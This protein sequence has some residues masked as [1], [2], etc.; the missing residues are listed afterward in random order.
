MDGDEDSLFKNPRGQISLSDSKKKIITNFIKWLGK[1]VISGVIVALVV[2]FLVFGTGWSPFTS[3]NIQVTDQISTEDE[4]QIV[5]ANS[6]NFRAEDVSI[7]VSSSEV[8][9]DKSREVDTLI[10]G[11]TR[12]LSFDLNTANQTRTVNRTGVTISNISR[13]R[14]VCRSALPPEGLVLNAETDRDRYSF[15]TLGNISYTRS[16]GVTYNNRTAFYVENQQYEITERVPA[17]YKITVTSG[18]NNTQDIKSFR[19]PSSRAI[20]EA[21]RIERGAAPSSVQ[22]LIDLS[23]DCFVNGTEI[24][25]GSKLINGSVLPA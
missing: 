10:E 17:R 15:F 13:T 6:G 19:Y 1:S 5:I 3:S 4:Y 7:R 11:Q 22:I 16:R 23:G 8:E 14:N 24:S 20:L 21:S 18:E 2:S 9:Y 12:I 25:D